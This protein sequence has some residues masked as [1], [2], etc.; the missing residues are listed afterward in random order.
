MNGEIVTVDEV[1]DEQPGPS[2]LHILS[3]YIH[4]CTIY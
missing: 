3:M 1:R 4:V 2:W